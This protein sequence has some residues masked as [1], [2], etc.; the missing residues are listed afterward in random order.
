MKEK[1][2]DSLCVHDPKLKQSTQPHVLPIHTSSSFVFDNIE[3]GIAIFK[4]EEKGHVY[5][6]YGNPT[7]DVVA[8][9]IR[10][11]ET[12]GTDISGG[13]LLTGTGMAAISS[14][15]MALV[16]SGDQV[17]TQGN[18]YGGTTELMQ[19]MLKPMGVNP[20]LTDLKDLNRVEE[21]LKAGHFKVLYFETP[22]NPT[23]SCVDIKALADLGK[24]YGVTTVIDN[25]FAS[26]M[27][28]QPLALGVDFVIHSTTKFLNGHGN[29]L[30]GV[31][32]GRDEAMMKKQVWDAMKL[33]GTSCS[34]FN[35]W[36]LNNGM[37]TLSLRMTRHCEN[38][39]AIAEFLESH[40]KVKQVNYPGLPSFSDHEIAK[41]QMSGFGGMLSF[42]LDGGVED[43]IQFMNQLQF[44]T[45]TPTLGNVDTLVLHPASSS[46]VNVAPEI[47]KEVGISD[48]L[49]RLSIGIEAAED[50]ID[51]LAQAIG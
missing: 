33:L 14:L 1:Q 4:G 30:A 16:K 45:L 25:T 29:S 24:Q 40:P 46:H 31:I 19:K 22:S 43:G 8:E 13:A 2:F 5:D 21:H 44:C 6:R 23:L 39:Q 28:Q 42:E 11:L 32:V 20:V 3:Q 47:R 34:P 12:R 18:L 17:L 9:K 36:L 37:K 15:L 48:G 38:A 26:P 41:K 27:L 49:I 51:D 7:V 50:I 35:A 10:R